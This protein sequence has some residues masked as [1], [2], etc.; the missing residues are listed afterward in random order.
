MRKSL[1]CLSQS[2][3]LA[4]KHFGNKMYLILTLLVV[5]L[6][7]PAFN[8]AAISAAKLGVNFREAG[9]LARDLE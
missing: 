7:K 4:T 6:L 9:A 2:R 5:G 3:D 8:M 1:F